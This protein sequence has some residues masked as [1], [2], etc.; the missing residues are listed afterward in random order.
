MKLKILFTDYSKRIH[1]RTH[2]H[3]D[4]TKLKLHSLKRAANGLEMA[5]DSSTAEQKIWQVYRFGER[6]VFRLQNESRECFCRRGRGMS[7][8]VDGPKTE[9][10]AEPAV[11]SW[12]EESG[13]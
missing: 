10:G 13:G 1:T 9:K 8:H 11:E 12:C 2:E 3:S 4:Y 6:R 7:F 5:E